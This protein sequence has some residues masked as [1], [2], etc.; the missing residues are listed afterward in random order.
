MTVEVT[1]IVQRDSV[2]QVMPPISC[3]YCSAEPSIIN[4]SKLISPWYETYP[5]VVT[6]PESWSIY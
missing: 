3:W 4:S 6:I 5:C 1:V 2:I